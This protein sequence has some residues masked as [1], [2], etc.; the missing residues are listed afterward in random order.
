VSEDITTR[1]E[2]VLAKMTAVQ[3]RR[4]QRRVEKST[5]HNERHQTTDA[6]LRL[7]LIHERGIGVTDLGREVNRLRAAAE[8][9]RVTKDGEG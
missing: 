6:L 3:K 2:A 7:G 5:A 4:L 8:P 1:A 9:S